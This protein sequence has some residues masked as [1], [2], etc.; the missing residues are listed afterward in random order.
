MPTPDSP[1]TAI[2]VDDY[3]V[4]QTL[5]PIQLE[6]LFPNIQV[7]AIPRKKAIENNPDLLW[8]GEAEELK[9]N[10]DLQEYM[11]AN[12][13][14]IKVIMCSAGEILE[15]DEEALQDFILDLYVNDIVDLFLAKPYDLQ[16]ERMNIESVFNPDSKMR[17]PVVRVIKLGIEMKKLFSNIKLQDLKNKL[18]TALSK[19]LRLKGA[20]EEEI[21]VFLLR[22]MHDIEF[23]DLKF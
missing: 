17:E 2:V 18:L 20:K 10:P 14:K 13:S 15:K 4:N 11:K 3:D 21:Q 9:R 23:T 16:K 12:R 1:K 19:H 8:V 6:T 22:M 5:V 7:A